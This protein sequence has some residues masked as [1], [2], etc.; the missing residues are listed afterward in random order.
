MGH[1]KTYLDS[2]RQGIMDVA[3][4]FGRENSDSGWYHGNM[5]IMDG[6]KPLPCWD[7]AVAKADEMCAERK[8]YQDFA[9]PYLEPGTEVGQSATERKLRE[10]IT[11][12]RKAEIEYVRKNDIHNRTAD[13]ITCPKCRSRLNLAY[14]QGYVC[15]LCR[16]DLRSKTV[17]D[18]I[19][20]YDA[21]LESLMERADAEH[22]KSERTATRRA[23]IV[24]WLVKVEVHC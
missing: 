11:K 16:T 19:A 18:R 23:G 12:T 8:D 4:E 2:D 9:I 20:K 1:H 17:Q 5:E 7:D 15:P 3:E 24:K 10:R 14:L 13:T 6:M 22:V 21:D